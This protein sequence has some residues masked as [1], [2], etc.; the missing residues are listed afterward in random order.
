VSDRD[1]ASERALDQSQRALIF[2]HRLC[3]VTLTL[4]IAALLGFRVFDIP[5]II[6]VRADAKPAATAT[7]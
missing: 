1:T 4:T 2:S 5:S 7:P 3:W 6:S